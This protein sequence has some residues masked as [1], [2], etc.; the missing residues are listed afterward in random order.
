M[1][2]EAKH[3]GALI[4]AVDDD[5]I[6]RELIQQQ[7]LALGHECDTT[8]SCAETREALAKKDYDLV[9]TDV[10]LSDGSVMELLRLIRSDSP[11]TVILMMAGAGDKKLAVDCFRKGAHAYVEKPIDIADLSVQVTNALRMRQLEM[12]NRAHRAQVDR[13]V[14]QRTQEL[15]SALKEVEKSCDMTIQVVCS[16][17]QMRLSRARAH[18]HLVPKVTV[19]LGRMLDVQ[20]EMLRDFERGACLRDVGMLGI[21]DPVLFEPGK[22]SFLQREEIRR[23]PEIGYEIVRRVPALSGAADIVLHHHERFNGTGYPHRLKEQE[24]PLGARMVALADSLG[25]MLTDRPYK[26]AVGFSAATQSIKEV[27]GTQLDPAVVTAF[28]RIADEVHASVYTH[29][30]P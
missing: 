4:L 18:G 8:G 24:I 17:V 10:R 6:I 7:L 23:H 12:E 28:L 21:P 30:Q 22:L 3:T 15:S 19:M 2:K 9:L 26:T 29:V 25:A 11:D 13:H 1:A 14:T 27:S 20:Q 16:A 5:L